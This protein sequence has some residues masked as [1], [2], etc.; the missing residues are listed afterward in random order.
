MVLSVD[1]LL[2]I[3]W[4]AVYQ[5]LDL[6]YARGVLGAVFGYSVGSLVPLGLASWTATER[7]ISDLCLSTDIATEVRRSEQPPEQA[8]DQRRCDS[9][10]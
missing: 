3:R 2:A 7:N 10:R 5:V 4:W 9:S 8:K 6:G 1:R